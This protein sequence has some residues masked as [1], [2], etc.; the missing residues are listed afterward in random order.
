MTESI[1]LSFSDQVYNYRDPDTRYYLKK[2][3]N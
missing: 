2:Y 3:L 1:D